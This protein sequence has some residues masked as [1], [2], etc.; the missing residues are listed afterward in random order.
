MRRIAGFLL[1][2]AL[3]AAPAFAKKK[4]PR[5]IATAKYVFITDQ[6]GSRT[7]GNMT[8]EDRAAVAAVRR[9]VRVWDRYIDVDSAEQADIIL[10]VEAARGVGVRNGGT[11]GWPTPG[12]GGVKIGTTGGADTGPN[13]DLPAVHL[14][15]V[16][17]PLLWQAAKSHG[18]DMPDVPLLKELRK[19]VEQSD[20]DEKQPKP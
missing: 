20:A 2:I 6:H 14:N 4:F 1:L 15:D 16:D 9:A 3:A 5:V 18:F 17:G 13:V 7:A 10:V 19:N 11:I 12:S 8:P